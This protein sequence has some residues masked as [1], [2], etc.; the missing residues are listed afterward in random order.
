MASLSSLLDHLY[1][2]GII[3]STDVALVGGTD[4]YIG[5]GRPTAGSEPCSEAAGGLLELKA[6]VDLVRQVMTEDGA[7]LWLRSPN[8]QFGDEKPLHLVGRGQH[9][10]VRTSFSGLPRASLPDQS[11]GRGR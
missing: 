7:R 6:V 11:D 3:D 4:V 9:Q 8:P 10:Q 5:T 2:S 1:E